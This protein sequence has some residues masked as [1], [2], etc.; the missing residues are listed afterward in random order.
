MNKLGLAVALAALFLSFNIQ[1]SNA[2]PAWKCVK[3]H[4]YWVEG[5]KGS[6]PDYAKE[7]GAPRQAGC[8]YSKGIVSKRW[9]QVCPPN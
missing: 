8:Y 2:E 4:C 5:Y 7:W 9:S 3:R 1:S 6:L